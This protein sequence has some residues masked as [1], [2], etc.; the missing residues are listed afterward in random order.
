MNRQLLIGGLVDR[1]LSLSLDDL[2]RFPPV[3]LTAVL[4]CSGNGRAFYRP[5]APGV[6]WERGA[7]GNA[8]W[9]GVRLAEVLAR[10]GVQPGAAHL[11]LLGS[12]R[13]A[14]PSVPLFRRS[15]PLEKA[16]HRDTLLA[17]A[18]NGEPLP[19]LHG[20]PVRVIAP[21]WMGDAWVKWVNEITVRDRESTGY[22]MEQ[23]YRYPRR[24]VAPGAHV[25][26][27][28]MEPITTMAVKSVIAAPRSGAVLSGL[29]IP[30]QGVAWTG[31]GRVAA[32]ELSVD[33][34][35]TWEPATF[36]GPDE[37][38]AWRLWRGVCRAPQPGPCEIWSRARDDRGAVQPLVS[39]WN[40]GGFLWNGI[41]RVRVEVVR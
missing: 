13:P 37:L 3:E 15:I 32:V 28:E 17:Y 29:D 31:E 16:L 5:R 38:Y 27:S 34:G 41:D 4:Q 30:V 2:R 9:T 14:F 7:V 39:P 40:P 19:P 1:R 12:D 36:T 10:A 18:M 23:A 35:R 22:Y 24:P 6:Q 26:T 11:E 33:E 8:R 25:L 20:G 21:G